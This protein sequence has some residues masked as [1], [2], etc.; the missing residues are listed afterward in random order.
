M[1][2]GVQMLL[3]LLH[4]M[5]NF[6]SI[7]MVPQYSELAFI[8]GLGRTL[9]CMIYTQIFRQTAIC[10]CRVLY[11]LSGELGMGIWHNKKTCVFTDMSNL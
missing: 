1:V 11:I 5:L 10:F 3:F 2:K 7:R 8:D 9:P 6:S 4:H